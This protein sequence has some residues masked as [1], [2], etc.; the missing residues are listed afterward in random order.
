M[1]REAG[2]KPRNPVAF[3]RPVGVRHRAIPQADLADVQRVSWRRFSVF[4]IC[5]R[6]A[7]WMSARGSVVRQVKASRLQPL[8]AAEPRGLGSGAGHRFLTGELVANHPWDDRRASTDP[9]SC[10]LVHRRSMPAP[11]A[12][13]PS[14]SARP[15]S[16]PAP[17]A[18]P[19]SSDRYP[20]TW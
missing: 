13:T 11:A 16:R 1:R 20:A 10:R 17:D 19:G 9:S 12:L 8:G 14:Q 4:L 3:P 5:A 7:T 6:M 15:R 18:A 2:L